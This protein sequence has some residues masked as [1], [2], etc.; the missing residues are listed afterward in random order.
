MR[1]Q[2]IGD[3]IITRAGFEPASPPPGGAVDVALRLYGPEC[4]HRGAVFDALRGRIG[5]DLRLP[6]RR[7]HFIVAI[8]VAQIELHRMAMVASVELV[9]AQLVAPACAFRAELERVGLDLPALADAFAITETC[10]AR[11][12]VEVGGL[13]G[14]VVTP[15]R[16]Y[17]DGRV[18]LDDS[19][20]RA[21]A[22][23][24]PRALHKIPIQDEPG[25]VA[26]YRRAG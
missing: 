23:A 12:V 4:I 24:N 5:V 20:A 15:D 7:L 17:R 1:H 6:P 2:Q 22:S 10:A 11:R 18:W 14:L 9:A 19:A 21:L 8:A 25:R 13:D 26:L 3:E 16:V